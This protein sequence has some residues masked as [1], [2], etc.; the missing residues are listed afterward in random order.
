MPSCRDHTLESLGDR[1]RCRFLIV[2][3]SS[4][5]RLARNEA[6][7]RQVNERIKEVADGIQGGDERHEFLCECSDASCTERIT[8]EAAEYDEVRASPRRFVIAPGHVSPEIEHVVED[9]GDHVVVEKD[10]VAGRV[11]DDLDP[12]S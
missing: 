6:F 12:R 10:G 3:G 1:F 5:E 8:L 2:N 4:A 9:E 7:F 11:A